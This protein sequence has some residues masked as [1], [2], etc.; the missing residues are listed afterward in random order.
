MTIGMPNG[1]R[2]PY[3]AVWRLLAAS[4]LVLA[5]VSGARVFAAESQ[6]PIAGV[7]NLN[8]ASSTELQLLPGVG[9]VR[10]VAIVAMRKQRGGF[11]RIED[12]LE[13]KGI[14]PQ[15]LKRMRPYA[16]LTGKTTAK[17]L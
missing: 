5:L 15:M 9:E 16:T 10:A 4:A 7:V 8:T 1:S 3:L 14:G 13:V 2:K 6:P 17:E 11:K 12:L